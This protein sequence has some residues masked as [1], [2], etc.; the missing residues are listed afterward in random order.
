MSSPEQ[1][2][3][4]FTFQACRKIH[5]AEYLSDSASKLP[6]KSFSDSNCAQRH[7][8]ALEHSFVRLASSQACRKIQRA[9]NTSVSSYGEPVWPSL[10][11]TCANRTMYSG[12]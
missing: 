6:R 9:E 8:S 11:S 7:M 5:R 10:A 2:L 1:R 12:P 3:W 4:L